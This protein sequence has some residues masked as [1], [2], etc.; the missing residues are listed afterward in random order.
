MAISNLEKY[1]KDLDDLLVEAGQVQ[2]SLIYLAYGHKEFLDTLIRQLNG[3]EKQANKLISELKPFL[4]I[5]QHWYSE[6]LAIVKQLLPDR[7]ADFIR[8]YEK[9]KNRKEI[10][11]ENYR[12][13]DACQ[14]LR[15]TRLGEV[16]ADSKA[17]LNLLD[18]QIAIVEAIKR[19]FESSLFDIKQLVQADL[20]D[21]ELD[22]ARELLKNKFTR[23]AGAIAGVVL[24][25]HLG[26]VCENHNVK[27]TKK[28]PSISDYNQA[29]K[30]AD[31]IETSQWRFHQHLADIRNKCDHSKTDEPT[32]DEVKD[33]VEGVAKVTKT[34]F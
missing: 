4:S 3:D 7:L 14:G 8:L 19:R 30:D 13:E 23:G 25:G 5:Y 22:A 11:F 2:N 27:I 10:S 1:R 34:I 26:Q 20:F 18:Q 24:E 31:V 28:H 29:L 21:S 15:M 32:V 33:L 6:A 9:P 16:K 17:A 12:I